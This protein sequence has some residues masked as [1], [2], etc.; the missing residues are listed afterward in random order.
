MATVEIEMRSFI[1][2]KCG[3]IVGVPADL[4]HCR[5]R[6]GG[7]LYCPTGHRNWWNVKPKEEPPASEKTKRQL[8]REILRAKHEAEQA[9]ARAAEMKES[10]PGN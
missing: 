1:C 4:L 2:W 5:Q 6:D 10:N 9:E 7:F 8:Q 3:V